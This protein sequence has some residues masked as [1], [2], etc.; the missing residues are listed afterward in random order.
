MKK[1][2][3]KVVFLKVTTSMIYAFEENSINGWTA[4]QVAND[5]FTSYPM[6]RF[7]ATR[8]A[9]KIGNTTIVEK[10]DVLDDKGFDEYIKECN[11]KRGYKT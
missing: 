11:K 9:Y 7:H 10:V 8:E 5:W 6:D 4:E 1:K 3:R 2:E